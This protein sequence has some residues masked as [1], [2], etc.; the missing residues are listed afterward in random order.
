MQI[1]II[2]EKISII[3]LLIIVAVFVSILFAPIFANKD[4]IPAKYEACAKLIN[5]I[6]QNGG[7][8]VVWAIFVKTIESLQKYLGRYLLRL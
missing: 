7:K 6:I 3:K 1:T 4:V 2:N 8:V 5:E